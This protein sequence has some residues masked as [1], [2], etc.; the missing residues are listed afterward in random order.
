MW[1]CECGTGN[2]EEALACISCG[3]ERGDGAREELFV[4]PPPT[5]TMERGYEEPLRERGVEEI[6]APPEEEFLIEE[7]RG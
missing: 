2:E 1:K 4:E 5:P 7:E 6:Y 3:Q